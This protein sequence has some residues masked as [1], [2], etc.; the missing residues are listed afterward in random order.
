[1]V[2][3]EL[4]YVNAIATEKSVTRAAQKLYISQS[5]LSQFLAEYER[6]LGFSIFRRTPQGVVLTSDG[7]Q[8]VKM[9]EKVLKQF[10]QVVSTI[11]TN[12]LPAKHSLKF[13]ISEQR[14]VILTH[15]LLSLFAQT[16]PDTK[17]DIIDENGR[18]LRRMVRENHLDLAL[19]TSLQGGDSFADG[20]VFRELM[21]EE[22][23]LVVPKIHPLAQKI[24]TDCAT[25]RS[26]VNIK[27][28]R[29]ET[30]VLIDKKRIMRKFIDSLIQKESLCPH[31]LQESTNMSTI[32]K[33][34]LNENALTFIPKGMAPN[35]AGD[36]FRY[37]SIGKRGKYWTLNIIT[38][39]NHEL[40]TP[41]Q[42][43]I[44][45]LTKCLSDIVQ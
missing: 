12:K 30:F 25:N 3:K 16:V 37:V 13:G 8:F 42:E 15:R 45:I 40:T 20:V 9:S 29:N 41:E 34:C 27:D 4:R 23:L 10:D 32:L 5:A 17:L 19:C 18:E 21:A 35:G 44:A 7:E 6:Q 24:N 28:L 11:T 22:F 38:A 14:A 43:L 36:D 33:I 31:I 39:P 26:W 1:M 2:L